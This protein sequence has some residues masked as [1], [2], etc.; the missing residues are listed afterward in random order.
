M[1]SLCLCQ[2]EMNLVK[3]GRVKDCAPLSTLVGEGAEGL[4]IYL[5]NICVKGMLFE[6]GSI[7][8]NQSERNL[9]NQ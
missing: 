6:H 8:I 7:V 2:L 4:P 5:L 1:S 9:V 3:G